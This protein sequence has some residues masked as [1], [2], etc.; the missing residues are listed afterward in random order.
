MMEKKTE[1]V[2]DLDSTL[3]FEEEESEVSQA[4]KKAKKKRY[5][6]LKSF[7]IVGKCQIK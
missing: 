4:E 1:K 6:G 2:H 3:I 7:F 5:G